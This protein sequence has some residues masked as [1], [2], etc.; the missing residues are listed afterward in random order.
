M[1][2]TDNSQTLVPFSSSDVDRIR[3]SMLTANANVVCPRCDRELTSDPIA[4][5]GSIE[6]VWE[7]RCVPCGRSLIISGLL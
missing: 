6:T 5:G 1:P 3:K 7:V 4:G 2:T